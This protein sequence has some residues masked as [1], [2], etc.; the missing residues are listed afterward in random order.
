MALTARRETARAIT[1][2]WVASLVQNDA[3]G[4]KPEVTFG[5]TFT[6]D[7]RPAVAISSVSSPAGSVLAFRVIFV[8]GGREV[9]TISAIPNLIV[10]YASAE[11]L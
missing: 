6:T 1:G 11:R 4:Y 7:S 8:D 3:D 9:R 2:R 5:G 10:A